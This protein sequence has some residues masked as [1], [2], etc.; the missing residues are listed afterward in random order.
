MRRKSV[1]WP[2]TCEE[3]TTEI[4]TVTHQRNEKFR[5]LSSY[6][7]KEKEAMWCGTKIIKRRRNTR[8]TSTDSTTSCTSEDNDMLSLTP[9]DTDQHHF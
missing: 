6:I 7:S 2:S 4:L 9:K 5:E 3:I 1:N 8:S